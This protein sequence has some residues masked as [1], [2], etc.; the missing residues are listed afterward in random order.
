MRHPVHT[1]IISGFME[2]VGVAIFLPLTFQTESA[3]A[4]LATKRKTL[5]AH[6]FLKLRI[7]LVF[8]LTLLGLILKM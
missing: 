2:D 5:K 6:A 3:L 8:F 4:V 7:K 1:L